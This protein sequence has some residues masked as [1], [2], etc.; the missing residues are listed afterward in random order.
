LQSLHFL[1]ALSLIFMLI[2]ERTQWNTCRVLLTY[3]IVAQLVRKHVASMKLRSYLTCV[4]RSPPRNPSLIQMNPV[5]RLTIYFFNI[6]ILNYAV[7]YTY[8]FQAVSSVNVAHISHFSHT[9]NMRRP[10]HPSLFYHPKNV[11]Q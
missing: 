7:I 8:D 10:L 5:H 11:N 3:L 9:C 6:H 1:I 2:T 4:Y